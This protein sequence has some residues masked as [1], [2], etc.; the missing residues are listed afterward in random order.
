MEGTGR[1][2]TVKVGDAHLNV[3]TRYLSPNGASV[4]VAAPREA[5]RLSLEVPDHADRLVGY[6]TDVRF[7]AASYM[8]DVAGPN[9]SLEV[10]V[11]GGEVPGVGKRVAVAVNPECLHLYPRSE[12]S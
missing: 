3:E 8:V 2:V 9:F 1:S 5:F 12:H 10:A 7:A 4:W 11:N 6:V